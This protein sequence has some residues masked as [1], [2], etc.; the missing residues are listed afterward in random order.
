M[1]S[2]WLA[3]LPIMSDHEGGAWI[4]PALRLRHARRAPRGRRGQPGIRRRLVPPSRR[5]RGIRA[6][7]DAGRGVRAAARLPGGPPGQHDRVAPRP[8][9]AAPRDGVLALQRDARAHRRD[10]VGPRHPGDRSP[11]RRGAHLHLRLHDGELPA[12][13]CPARGS[14]DRLRPSEPDRRSGGRRADARRGVRVVRR[15]VPDPDA[16]RHDDWRAGAPVQ[17]A[18]R[19]RRRARSGPARGMATGHVPG[20]RPDFRG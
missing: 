14:R 1:R 7:R 15:P 19:H 5:P 13:G 4:R 16:P 20:T 9:R 17:R 8:R 2:R 3:I 12:R 18:L 11:G 10:A 6:R